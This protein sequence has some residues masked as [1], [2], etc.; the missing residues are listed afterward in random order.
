MSC[1]TALEEAA[2]RGV[3]VRV[4]F[5]HLG[6]LRIKG[7]RK[8][9]RRLKA[10]KIQWRP[11]LPLLPDARPVAPPG[12]AQPPQD[13]GDRRR[14][15]LHRLAEP[16]RA[17]LQQPPAPQGGPRMG[18][19]DGL[20]ARARSSPPSTSSSPPTGSAR[21]T[22]SLEHQ[23]RAPARTGIRATSRPRWCPAAPAS[24]P[25]TTCGSS[26]R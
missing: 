17:L 19:A 5:D 1:S 4:L 26:T 16:D 15:R 20:P 8:L 25:R 13:H 24:S 11:M 12:P 7:Y 9:I 2:E 3:E 10:S 18:G 6:T 22:R 14:N 21:P 23:L